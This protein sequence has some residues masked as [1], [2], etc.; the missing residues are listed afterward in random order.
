MKR[1]I[2]CCDGTWQK[3]TDPCP[4]NVVKIAQAIKPVASD[5]TLQLLYYDEGVGTDEDAAERFLGGAFGKGIDQNI[6][7][8]YRFLCLNYVEGDEIYLF[9]FSRGAYTV[10]SL[11]GLMYNTG[12]LKRENIR[13]APEAYQLY[14][15]RGIA[16]SDEEA[17]DFRKENSLGSR[18]E[19]TLL[20]C[21]DTVGSLGIPDLSYFGPLTQ[22]LNN[23]YRFHDTQLNKKIKN[24]LHAVAIDEQRKVFNVTPMHKHPD[25]PDQ[26]LRQVWFPGDHGCVGGGT[27][28]KSKLADGTLKWM[29]ESIGSLGLGLEFDISKI[30]PPLDFDYTCDFQVKSII[31]KAT[32]LGGTILREIG[33]EIDELHESVKLRWKQRSDYRPPNLKKYLDKLEA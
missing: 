15:N 20:G 14:C 16:P 18:V 29:I 9:G 32:K 13:Q 33:D 30:N 31:E 2:V 3:L 11:A 28:K 21:W 5:G 6:Q 12:L 26:V 4:T 10:R 27:L 23:Q 17:K 7:D 19:I 8:A 25:A 1:L 22:Q 24:A